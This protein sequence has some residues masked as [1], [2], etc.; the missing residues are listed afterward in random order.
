MTIQ[1]YNEKSDRQILEILQSYGVKAAVIAV[2]SGYFV[3]ENTFLEGAENNPELS[4]EHIPGVTDDPVIRLLLRGVAQTLHAQREITIHRKSGVQP[5][6]QGLLQQK[7][8]HVDH[9]N[10]GRGRPLQQS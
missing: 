7:S 3:P 4:H 2:D 5:R 6:R 1:T 8:N 10:A 9:Q